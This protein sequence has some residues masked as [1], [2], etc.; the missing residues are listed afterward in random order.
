MDD[1]NN[2]NKGIV[3]H[4]HDVRD[5]NYGNRIT[6]VQKAYND[7]YIAVEREYVKELLKENKKLH[8][9]INMLKDNVE[10]KEEQLIDFQRQTRI[11]D[12]GLDYRDTLL[13][14]YENKN[15]RLTSIIKI[16]KRRNSIKIHFNDHPKNS[17]NTTD[18]TSKKN[19][20]NII[21]KQKR[22]AIIKK[23]RKL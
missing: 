23:H 7:R 14:E 22:D 15:N 13:I 12:E 18:L 21:R 5:T 2:I 8:K 19:K 1:T 6:F 11:S 3:Y 10:D 4:T 20:S 16:M 9:M 17:S